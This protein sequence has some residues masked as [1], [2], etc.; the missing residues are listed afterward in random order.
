MCRLRTSVGALFVFFAAFA[1][2]DAQWLKLPDPSIPRN[3]DGSPNLAAPAPRTPDGRPDLSG[4][5]R[6]LHN[7]HIQN[8]AH[9]LK[10]VPFQPWAAAVYRERQENNGLDRPSGKCLP[11]SVPDGMILR[12]YPIKIVQNPKL[13]LILYE[14]FVDYRQIHTDGRTFA[15]FPKDADEIHPAWFGYSIGRWDGDAFVVETIGINERTWLDDSGYPHSNALKVTERF[16][17]KDFGSL[18]IEFTFDDPKAYSRP[19]SVTIPFELLPDT[20]LL[21]Y[22]CENEKDQPHM[23]GK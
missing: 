23:V 8:L 1:T 9:E 22:V 7:R 19:W 12:G 17:R 15:G 11:K 10:E 18:E 6:A 2:L 16:R 21:E 4:I 20:E 13:T 3:V 5:W 14:I